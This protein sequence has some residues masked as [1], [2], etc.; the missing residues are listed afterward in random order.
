MAIV[1]D[2]DTYPIVLQG[3]PAE[4]GERALHDLFARMSAIAKRSIR[5]DT[6]HVIVALGD[7]HFTAAERK[8]VA[9]QMTIAPKDEAARVVGAFAVIESGFARGVLTALHWLSPESIPV[10]GAP[11]PEAAV[12]MA[13]ARLRARGVP[14][15]SDTVATVTAAAA[16]LHAACRAK[17]A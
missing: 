12:E 10:V 2:E 15:G 5:Q 9:D 13:A 4:K 16:K 3:F 14:V 17:P 1:V 7:E 11:T 8:L 6:V